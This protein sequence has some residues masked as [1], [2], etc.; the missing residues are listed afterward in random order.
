[1]RAAALWLT[2]AGLTLALLGGWL[3]FERF[4]PLWSGGF[5]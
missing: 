2:W 3:W 5:K 4:L 1:M